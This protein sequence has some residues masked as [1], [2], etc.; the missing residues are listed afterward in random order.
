MDTSLLIPVVAGVLGLLC[1][2]MLIYALTAGPK[3]DY[4]NLMSSTFDPAD[5]EDIR[6]RLQTD[7]SGEEFERISQEVRKRKF[8][9]KKQ[10][11]LQEQM[12][13]A[14][15]FS[16]QQRR[17]FR[18]LQVA[19]PAVCSVV[20]AFAGLLLAD[21]WMMMMGLLLGGILGAYVPF[22]V[23]EKRTKERDEAILYYLPLVIEQVSIGVSSSLDVGPCL[24]R[25]IQ[26]ANERDTHNPVT[27]LLR[28]AQYHVKSGVGLEEALGDIGKLSGHN[29]LKHAFMA[30]A[31]VAKFGGEVTRQLQELAD[32]VSSQRETKVEAK[33]KKLELEATA[34]VALVFFG[35]LVILLIG[36]GLQIITAM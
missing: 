25:I 30:L 20:F 14:G 23:I 31:Q 33:I 3:G 1:L 2:G 10:E 12:F 16:E 9:K 6:E 17:D 18:R 34:P 26:M 27:E 28:Y 35:Y 8:G 29:E 36:F 15:I 4:R 32:A 22:K 5:R 21:V 13:R 7:E 24:Q 11:T 19:C